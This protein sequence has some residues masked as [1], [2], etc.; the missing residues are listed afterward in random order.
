M[1]ERHLQEVL[2]AAPSSREAGRVKAAPVG[3]RQRRQVHW[4]ANHSQPCDDRRAKV[5]HQSQG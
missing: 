4:D 3:V 2:D 5:E 1:L